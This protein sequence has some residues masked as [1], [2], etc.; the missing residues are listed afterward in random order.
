MKK[1]IVTLLSMV[2][3]IGTAHAHKKDYHEPQ[4]LKIF[5]L[6][7]SGGEHFRRSFG[8]GEEWKNCGDYEKPPVK[9]VPEL[10]A[11][12]AAMALALLAGV[13]LVVRE[14]RRNVDL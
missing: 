13:V 10:D 4:G 7:R 3:S 1:I 14:R 8:G 6:E 12:S 9:A 2:F 11:G 5:K